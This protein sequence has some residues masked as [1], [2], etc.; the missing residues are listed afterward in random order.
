MLAKDLL[1][2]S[3]PLHNLFLRFLGDKPPTRRQARRFLAKF[4]Q[5]KVAKAA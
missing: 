2:S 3:H 5:Y 1:N 4:P